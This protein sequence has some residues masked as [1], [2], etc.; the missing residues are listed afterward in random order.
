MFE[1]LAESL[2]SSIA[3]KFKNFS[4]HP[5]IQRDLAF[6]V[7]KNKPSKELIKLITNK[8]GKNL[9]HLKVFDVYEGTGIPEG[10]KSIAFSLTWQ[11]GNRTLL[12]KEVDVFIKK[13]I[14]SLS[15]ELNAKLRT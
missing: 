14:R 15:K 9:T 3:T 7:S 2:D 13:I 11:A 8:A 1:V 6:V 5:V 10:K 12:D 4:R